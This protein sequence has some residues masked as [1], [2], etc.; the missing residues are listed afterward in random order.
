[1]EPIKEG[2]PIQI[3]QSSCECGDL[4]PHAVRFFYNPSPLTDVET[5]L[6]DGEGGKTPPKTTK[7]I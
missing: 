7:V 5:A 4:L 2:H 1:M 3:D 6:C